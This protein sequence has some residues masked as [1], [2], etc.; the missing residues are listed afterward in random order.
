MNLKEDYNS[1]LEE[2]RKESTK[3][4]IKLILADK[5]SEDGFE[6]VARIVRWFEKRH[7]WPGFINQNLLTLCHD[8]DDSKTDNLTYNELSWINSA[9]HSKNKNFRQYSDYTIYFSIYID[10]ELLFFKE[11]AESLDDLKGLL[12]T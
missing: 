11:L 6:G 10:N 5:L 1:Y 7:K 2:I 9:F 8:K 3:S 4:D 12:W